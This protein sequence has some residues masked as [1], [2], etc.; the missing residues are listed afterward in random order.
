M[1]SEAQKRPVELHDLV[2]F[3]G[4]WTDAALGSFLHAPSHQPRQFKLPVCEVSADYNESLGLTHIKW[5]QLSWPH[6][7]LK[8]ELGGYWQKLEQYNQD[9]KSEMRKYNSIETPK[10]F[11]SIASC[12]LIQKVQ[13]FPAWNLMLP[14]SNGWLGVFS[15]KQEIMFRKQQWKARRSFNT[16]TL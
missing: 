7:H 12:L 5:C 16:F 4:R 15:E 11:W 13:S 6:Q 14:G 1:F 8:R 9:S 3:L 10:L 2:R